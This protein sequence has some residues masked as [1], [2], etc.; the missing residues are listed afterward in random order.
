[1]HLPGL[2][3]I[4]YWRVADGVGAAGGVVLLRSW[5]FVIFSQLTRERRCS[6]VVPQRFSDAQHGCIFQVCCG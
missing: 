2:L 6:D 1:M 5:K 3:W 4:T